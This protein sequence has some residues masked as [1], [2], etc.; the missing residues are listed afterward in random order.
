MRTYNELIALSS[1][2]ERLT[3]LRV[4]SKLGAQNMEVDRYFAEQFYR[5]G[6]WKRIR[7]TVLLRDKFCDLGV[8]GLEIA[9]GALIHH[10]NPISM[11]DIFKS[12][13][14]ML[15]DPSNLITCSLQ[16]HNSIHYGNAVVTV[17]ERQPND[18]I[19]WKSLRKGD[20]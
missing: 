3:Y 10:I 5:S 15:F 20:N 17:I 13:Y 1:F 2:H 6:E 14:E 18:T 8:E 19:P 11:E 9:S 7:R 4:R 16:T 12:R